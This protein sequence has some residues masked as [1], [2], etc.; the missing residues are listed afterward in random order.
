MAS[1]S[2]LRER[3]AEL[4]AAIDEL[5]QAR[6]DES[7]DLPRLVIIGGGISDRIAVMETLCGMPLQLPDD[8]DWERFVFE[9]SLRPAPPDE[10]P[11]AVFHVLPAARRTKDEVVLLDVLGGLY[12]GED[13]KCPGS[14][15]R[16][17]QSGLNTITRE[18]RS[19]LHYEHDDEDELGD[20]IKVYFRGPGVPYL[21]F[22]HH[23]QVIKGFTP[24]TAMS[25]DRS[26]D[27]PMAIPLLVFPETTPKAV[28]ADAA[29]AAS[30]TRVPLSRVSAV[31][32]A[33]LASLP[34]LASKSAPPR[35]PLMGD[36]FGKGLSRLVIPKQ[37]S[38]FSTATHTGGLV[39][40][41][42]LESVYLEWIASK[43]E[44]VR[45]SLRLR[46]L[47]LGDRV[48]PAFESI[49]EDQ[50]FRQRCLLT[51]AVQYLP[52][53]FEEE[54]PSPT[55]T[56]NS[57]TWI[58]LHRWMSE[59][60]DQF[61][62]TMRESGKRRRVI[63]DL[64]G[65]RPGAN[66]VG[67]AEYLRE[68]QHLMDWHGVAA[69]DDFD[70]KR[71]GHIITQ[72]FQHQSEPWERI[73]LKAMCDIVRGVFAV[74][75]N[76]CRYRGTAG[77]VLSALLAPHL[78]R[79]E[80]DLCESVAEGF[81]PHMLARPDADC[82]HV[83]T[84]AQT[85]EF[86]WV[87]EHVK[88]VFGSTAL[89][90]QE[91]DFVV[92]KC[93]FDILT[94]LLG[95]REGA[96]TERCSEKILRFA[97]DYYATCMEQFFLHFSNLAGRIY[98]EIPKIV[99]RDTVCKTSDEEIHR[100]FASEPNSSVDPEDEDLHWLR[101]RQEKMR[102][103]CNNVVR[104]LDALGETAADSELAD[105]A[106]LPLSES[107][108]TTVFTP[109]ETS[110]KE[111]LGPS[112]MDGVSVC[113]HK[114]VFDEKSQ[115]DEDDSE[116]QSD[117]DCEGNCE[118]DSEDDEYNDEYDDKYGDKYDDEEDDYS[119]DEDDEDDEDDR[120]EYRIGTENAV[121]PRPSRRIP[122]RSLLNEHR[123]HD[124]G[125]NGNEYYSRPLFREQHRRNRP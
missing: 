22:L 114:G 105:P 95:R 92:Q 77:A 3:H 84:T 46:A 12:R 6:V 110:T 48:A 93:Q 51:E 44:Q 29:R 19:R 55:S 13:R 68:I 50:T 49:Y 2:N 122:I 28:L 71:H 10:E 86:R 113:E 4:L 40:Q 7:M 23:P 26:L 106:V 21:D 73:A 107:D 62:K 91:G 24:S 17:L 116:S 67:R 88:K 8:K 121:A 120:R 1:P 18:V 75:A 74:I 37:P 60:L 34:F 11:S 108:N 112:P 72:L 119:D 81:R 9:F 90:G 103:V 79:L 61:Q 111:E 33:R 89:D 80:E 115:D 98:I 59:T 45:E 117:D 5:R 63:W 97:E 53:A 94:D 102:T 87:A 16:H 15:L 101:D 43:A 69:H 100:L 52:D 42:Q 54:S 118:C 31:A 20:T 78:T 85:D 82:L 47:E 35:R 66:E 25:A 124:D 64:D 65:R 41:Q 30:R 83:R 27:S 109:S 123:S 14:R 76:Q 125:V 56:R 96:P 104:R 70:A 38:S 36:H 99:S 57:P 58:L 39:L 32:L